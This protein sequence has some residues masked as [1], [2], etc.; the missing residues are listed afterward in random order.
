MCV[1]GG[2][3]AAFCCLWS[4]ERPSSP[5]SQ[6]CRP[7][8]LRRRCRG[9]LVSMPLLFCPHRARVA[10]SVMIS[11]ALP[12]IDHP[13]PTPHSSGRMQFVPTVSKGEFL[14]RHRRRRQTTRRAVRCAGVCGFMLLLPRMCRTPPIRR[15]LCSLFASQLPY[16]LHFYPPFF[17]LFIAPWLLRILV[18]SPTPCFLSGTPSPV[19]LFL[20]QFARS[21]RL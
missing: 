6:Q 15:T 19:S 11:R 2:P 9:I 17:R 1:W 18:V 8:L 13:L 7:F 12:L 10:T 4:V 5:C 3:G 14:A 16:S 21:P 20:S